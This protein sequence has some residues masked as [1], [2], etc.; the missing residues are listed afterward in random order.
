LDFLNSEFLG[1]PL[2][3]WTAFLGIVLTLLVLDLG[4]FHRKAKEI[5][6]RESLWMSAFYISIGLLFG[7]WVWH[8]LGSQAGTEYLTGFLVEK[9]LA[10]DN[11]FVISLIFTYFAVPAAYQHR[12]LF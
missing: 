5:G 6:V 4:L 12:V 10:L 7:G 9:T 2:W 1:K 8:G 3:M 11:I